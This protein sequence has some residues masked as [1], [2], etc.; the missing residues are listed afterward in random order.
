MTK[1]NT[2]TKSLRIDVFSDIACPF[3]FIGDT[4]LARVLCAHENL[5]LDWHWHPFQLQPSLPKRGVPWDEFSRQKFGSLEG[6]RAAFAQVIRNGSS[7]GI[8]FDFERMVVAPNTLDAHRLVL[9]ASLQD[10]GKQ[11]SR[12]LYRAYFCEAVDITDAAQLERI[13]VAVG[14]ESH[15]VGELLVGETFSAQ[16]RTS[17]PEASK[18]GISGVPFYVFDQKYALFGAQP[19]ATFEMAI[20]RTLEQ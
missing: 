14:L 19:T 10:L 1:I 4:R 13:A 3:C 8:A 2:P 18:L 20:S 12:A 11:M 7:E 17:Q 15:A 5:E 16:V 6:R 9:L